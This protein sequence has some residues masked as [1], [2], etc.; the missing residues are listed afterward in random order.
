MENIRDRIIAVL[1]ERLQ[2]EPDVQAVWLEGADALNCVDEYSDIDLCC[3]VEGELLLKIGALAQSTLE[4]LGT[5]DLVNRLD[6]PDFQRHTVFHLAGTS[7]F[8]LVDFVAYRAGHGSQFTIG[9]EIE[10]PL[11]VFDRGGMIQYLSQEE[12]IARQDRSGRLQDLRKTVAQ[13]SR[14]EKY[15]KRG[16]LMEAFGYYHKWLVQPL[17]EVLRMKYTPLHPDYYIVHISRHMPKDV[18][19]QLEDLMK[20]D[21]IAELE[22]KSRAALQLFEVTAGELAVQ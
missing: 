7:P 21:S 1:C 11:V 10:K 13:Y 20:F 19:A 14:L 15:L 8:L 4:R 6:S 22:Q 2:G 16:N 9:D 3:S 12:A 17:I 18:L 5:V